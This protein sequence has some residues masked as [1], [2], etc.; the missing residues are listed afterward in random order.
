MLENCE[1]WEIYTYIYI[2]K[3]NLNRIHQTAFGKLCKICREVYVKLSD[4]FIGKT[5]RITIVLHTKSQE[6][7]IILNEIKI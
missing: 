7:E 4:S 6:I 1:D 3:V 2:S 5:M